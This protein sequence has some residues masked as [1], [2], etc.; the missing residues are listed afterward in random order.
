MKANP[1]F[2]RNSVLNFMLACSHEMGY[3]SI[4]PPQV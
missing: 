1:T 2:D 3:S 4:L